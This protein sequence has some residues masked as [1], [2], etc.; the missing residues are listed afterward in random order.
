MQNGV[1][2]FRALKIVY[3]PDVPNYE[4]IC[5]GMKKWVEG[6]WLADFK[7][8]NPEVSVEVQTVDDPIE[9]QGDLVWHSHGRGGGGENLL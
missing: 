7:A 6:S 5:G 4:Y 2:H 1:R 8:R 3:R 9:R